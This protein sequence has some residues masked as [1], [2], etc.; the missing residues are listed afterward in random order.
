MFRS[1]IC[2]FVYSIFCAASCN[3]TS[4]PENN[5][6]PTDTTS[7]PHTNLPINKIKLP[8][9][10]HIAVYAEGVDGARSMAWGE[11]GTLFVGSRDK[12]AYA[13]VDTDKNGYGDKIYT[14]AKGLNSPNGLAFKNGSLYLAEINKVWRYDN[15]EDQLDNIP[16]PVLVSDKFPSDAHHGW[17]YIAFGPDGKLYIPV[18][19]PCNVCEKDENQY[20]NIMRMNADGSGLETFAKGIRNTVGFGWHPQTNELWFTDNG[21]DELGDNIPDDELNRAPQAGMHFGFPYCHAGDIKDPGFGDKHPCSD[22]TPPVQKLGA[23]VAALGM[24]F[25]SG[26]QFP[27]EYNN[28]IFI[29]QH[30]SWN[31]SSKIG[32]RVMRVKLDGNKSAGYE[33]FAEGWLEENGNVWGRPVDVLVMPDGS[34]LVSDDMADAIYKITYKK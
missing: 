10:F 9:G 7:A 1:F 8:A 12:D 25:Y 20:A 13:I 15:I 32:Y 4:P 31:R 14:I 26:N 18:G 5:N 23:H 30:G 27:Q 3:K 29:A 6:K 2:F 19:A 11:K 33:P 28:N 21:R 22:Y 16:Q 24:K 17:K 34:L